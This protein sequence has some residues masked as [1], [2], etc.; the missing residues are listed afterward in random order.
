[1]SARSPVPGS[2]RCSISY[3]RQPHH[4]GAVLSPDKDTKGTCPA[5]AQLGVP[6][7]SPRPEN[8]PLCHPAQDE[9]ELP[10]QMWG[11]AAAPA[12][13]ARGHHPS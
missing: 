10:T 8:L 11:E 12:E 1:M 5:Q 9:E 3:E 4:A 13:R 2:Q 7:Q 6:H